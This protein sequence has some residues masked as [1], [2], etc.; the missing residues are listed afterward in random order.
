MAT[1]S[2]LGDGADHVFEFEAVQ[3][4]GIPEIGHGPPSDVIEGVVLG[5]Q[6]PPHPASLTSLSCQELVAQ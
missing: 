3:R 5:L 2:D 4:L 6:L 1:L